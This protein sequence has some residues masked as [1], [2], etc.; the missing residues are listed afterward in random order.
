MPVYMTQFAYTPEA[1][2]AL[3]RNPED[4]SRVL[5]DHLEKVGGKLLCFYYAFSEYDGVAIFEAP[6]ETAAAAALLAVVAPGH[7]RSIKTTALLTVE[8]A[9]EGMRQ[10]SGLKYRPPMETGADWRPY[11]DWPGPSTPRR[12]R[13]AAPGRGPGGPKSGRRW[14][15]AP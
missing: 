2:A 9:M 11:H 1:W 10:A 6:D 7:D 5:G 13:I 15:Y 3:I 4:R 12:E 14:R 8:Q